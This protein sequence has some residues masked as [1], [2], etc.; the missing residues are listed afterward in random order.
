MSPLCEKPMIL[1]LQHVA[2]SRPIMC[3][4]PLSLQ[5]THRFSQKMIILLFI[6][7]TSFL[8]ARIHWIFQ[9]T[10]Q[11]PAP[12]L[13]L[14]IAHLKVH[15]NR[16][17]AR[18]ASRCPMDAYFSEKTDMNNYFLEKTDMNSYLCTRNCR[19]TPQMQ[20]RPSHQGRIRP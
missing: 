17:L 2:A 9:P 14:D 20:F 16:L 11:Q 18:W 3:G 1:W 10:E 12:F 19:K 5:T 13:V 8:F 4:K 6:E 15:T 7:C